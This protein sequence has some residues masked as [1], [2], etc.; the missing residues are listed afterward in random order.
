[1]ARNRLTLLRRWLRGGIG[2]WLIL[3][4]LS[5]LPACQLVKPASSTAAPTAESGGTMTSGKA[6]DI[7]YTA[8]SG[9]PPVD[10]YLHIFTDGRAELYVGTYASVP[11]QMSD[12]VGFYGM[13]VPS[14]TLSSLN[15]LILQEKFMSRS[16]TPTPALPSGTVIRGVTLTLDGQQ[17]RLVMGDTSKDKALSKLEQMLTDIISQAVKYPLR[18]AQAALS[19]SWDGPEL[20]PVLTIT[21]VGSQPLPLVLFDPNDEGNYLE[22]EF[23]FT[24]TNQFYDSVFTSRDDIAALVKAGSLSSG[25]QALAPGSSYQVPLPA[26]TP[27]SNDPALQITGKLTF[28]LPDATGPQVRVAQVQTAAVSLPPVTSSGEATGP[29]VLQL[30]V[31]S[32]KTSYRLSDTIYVTVTL[33]NAGTA[34]LAVNGRLLLNHETA[35]ESV[36]DLYFEINGP[37]GYSNQRLF[38]VNAGSPTERDVVTLKAG[39]TQERAIELTRFYSLHLPGK[40]TLIAHYLNATPISGFDVWQGTLLSSPL[41]LERR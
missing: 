12:Q 19:L 24:Q 3:G 30:G 9:R 25:V 14:D 35:P 34:P 32:A 16:T 36:R 13:T 39:G 15:N 41:V 11:G 33:R 29:S 23:T 31:T 40:Y 10:M 20:R 26:F 37:P 5:W 18:A 6:F 2:L 27:P 17:T 21:D 7:F 8:Y 4:S 1:M 22:V 28:R 38:R